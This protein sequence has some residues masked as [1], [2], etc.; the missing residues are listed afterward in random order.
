VKFSAGALLA[1]EEYGWPG[2]IRELRNLVER[3]MLL[4]PENE[5]DAATVHAV[6]PAMA[7]MRAPTST[8]SASTLAGRVEQFEREVILSELKRGGFHI[9]N[10]AKLLGIERSHLYKK[11][12]QLGIDIRKE[13]RDEES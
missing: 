8:Q 6:L 4:S 11:A 7:E 5:V 3:L 13:R 10:T 1:L 12:E 2:N 9:T